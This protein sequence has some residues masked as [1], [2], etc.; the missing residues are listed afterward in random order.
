MTLKEELKQLIDETEDGLLQSDIVDIIWERKKAINPKIKRTTVQPNVSRRLS[1]LVDGKKIIKTKENKYYPYNAKVRHSIAKTTIVCSRAFAKYKFF[2]AS[3][4]MI[5]LDVQRE[6]VKS[7][8]ELFKDYLSDD[9]FGF[10]ELNG[11]LV[12]MLV[13]SDIEK[14]IAKKETERQKEIEKRKKEGD[15]NPDVKP[16]D[17][18]AIEKEALKKIRDEISEI[19]TD[20][21]KFDA[22]PAY[23]KSLTVTKK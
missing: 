22:T 17:V 13:V 12:L 18:D 4:S 21:E 2:K 19:L 14:I 15:N 11:Y 8:G 23:K 9:C 20:A 10:Y 7:I 16:L 1:E 5:Y 3:D 6:Q